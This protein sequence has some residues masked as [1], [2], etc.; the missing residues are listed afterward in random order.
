MA[1]ANGHHEIAFGVSENQKVIMASGSIQGF[2][3]LVK[4]TEHISNIVLEHAL[5]AAEDAAAAVLKQAFIEASPHKTGKLSRSALIYES[6]DRKALTG[7]TRRRLL[8]GPGKKSGYY[9]YFLSRGWKTAGSRR[10][11]RTKSGNTHSQSGTYTRREV[12]AP[13]P[14]WEQ[15]V[16]AKEQ[17][18][19]EAGVRAFQ[20]VISSELGG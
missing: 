14:N 6:V 18:A 17:E 4:N 20:E 15:R 13:Y 8:V 9:G 16:A 19:F 10:I 12:K 2:D 5:K 3:Q 11:K 7:T 1:K